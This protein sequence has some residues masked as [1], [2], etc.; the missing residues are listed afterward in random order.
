MTGSA[1]KSH[2]H[3]WLS[4]LHCAWT[5]SNSKGSEYETALA[6]TVFGVSE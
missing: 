4:V 6:N 3:R 5:V 1:S 2:L